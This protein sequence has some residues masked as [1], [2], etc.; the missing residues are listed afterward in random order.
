M[1]TLLHP[2]VFDIARGS[3][4]DGPGIRSVAFLK[5]CPLRC[6]WCHNPEGQRCGTEEFYDERSCIH[7]NRCAQGCLTG[8]RSTVGSRFTSE[9]LAD[10]LLKDRPFFETSGGGVTFSGGEPLMHCDYLEQVCV[11]LKRAGVHIT[12]ETC[13]HFD[14]EA[15]HRRLEGLVDLMLFDLKLADPSEHARLTDIDNTL[16]LDN[17]RRVR[18]SPVACLT[19]LPLVPGITATRENMEALAG[20]V[21]GLGPADV[22]FLP[23]NPSGITKMLKLGMPV[24]DDFPAEPMSINEQRHWESVFAEAYHWALSQ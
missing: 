19:R 13:G 22:E 17:Y 1:N 9:E 21:A 24:P 20:I 4:V 10:R 12:V 18:H 23:Y 14:W 7:C 11:P 15:F 2:L 5:G 8:A 6:V 3:Y 16:I